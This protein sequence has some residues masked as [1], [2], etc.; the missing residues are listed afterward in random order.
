M[1]LITY[2]EKFVSNIQPSSERISAV[3]GAHNDLRDHLKDEAQL[4][5][6]IDTSFLTGSYA[7]STATAPIK[8]VDIIL[9]LET[10]EVS[11]DKKQ[12]SP[13]AVL[14]DLKKAIDDFYDEVNLE[15]Q[16]RSIQIELA[17]DDIRMDVVPAIAPDGKEQQ[18]FV[19]DYGQ[20]CWVPSHPKKHIQLAATLNKEIDGRF[21][22]LVKAFKWWKSKNLRKEDAPKSFLLE[23]LLGVHV[24]KQ[25]TSL[26]KTFEETLKNIKSSFQKHYDGS[27]L[28]CIP[29]P[30]VPDDDLVQT[31]SWTQDQ[32]DSFFDAIVRALEIATKAND[33]E[34]TKE[35]TISLWQGL[36]GDEYPNTLTD[37]E[38]KALLKSLEETSNV[39]SR[40]EFSHQVRISA[41][42]AD[43][44]DGPVTEQY[45]DNG[46]RLPKEIWLRFKFEETTV[47]EP[48]QIRWLVTNHGKEARSD[49]KLTH[50]KYPGEQIHWE[51]AKYKGRHYM[52]CEVIK[53]DIVVAKTRHRINIR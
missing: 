28:P 39:P 6:A 21:V 18:L 50:D 9:I 33:S 1:Q 24:D 37:E 42:L 46:P 2:F 17:E 25:S 13:R 48:F 26:C 3:A 47:P 51:F 35:D 11:E 14:E 23:S 38:E 32:F 31:C 41:S 53:N 7:R 40:R 4:S 43:E 10:K 12:P 36:L 16:R 44:L 27:T 20:N 52:D 45:P 49:N 22:R 5:F 19:P 30:G 8:D 29:D 34:T 15:T